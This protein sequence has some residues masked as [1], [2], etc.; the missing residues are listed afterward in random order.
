MNILIYGLNY[1]SEP[2]GTGKYTG[3]MAS[4][5]ARRGHKVDA[6]VA[7]PYYP[8]WEIDDSYKKTKYIRETL[9]GVNVYRAPL[10]VPSA[11]NVNG[12]TRIMM[13]TSFS[14]NALRWWLPKFFHKKYDVVIAV[15]PPM[16]IGVY[17]WLYSRFIN[18]PWVFHIQDLQVDAAVRLGILKSGLASR[19]LYSIENFLLS[20]ATRVS[21]I[22]EA[23]RKRIIDKGI[24]EE[25]TW[26]FPNWSDIEFIKPMP[27]NNA[28]R[29]KIGI[30]SEQILLMYAGNM[31]EKQGLELILYAADKLRNEKQIKFVL[32]GSGA[33]RNRLENTAQDLHLN[34]ITFLPVQPLERLP[35]MLAAAD[36]HLVVQKRE[37]ADIVMPS[38]LTNILAAG[39]CC[40]A[41]ADPGTTLYEVVKHNKTGI[42]VSPE[43]VDEFIRGLNILL[44]NPDLREEMGRNA[45]NYAEKFI[46]KEQVLLDFES[47]LYSLVAKGV[48][49]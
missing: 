13:E 15:C 23:M 11:D 49:K 2:T 38:K 35:D 37:A 14:F 27:R 20:K 19:V 29:S 39:R 10:Y 22:T 18:V 12:K 41:T 33:V 43:D 44:K 31:G 8:D 6:I 17:P 40:L 45:R 47:K 48:V 24:P 36:I 26:L 9:N 42:V 30:T 3:E 28:F 32:V 1:A 7:P 5:L 34:N 46:D 16:Q 25:R 4:W 21:T